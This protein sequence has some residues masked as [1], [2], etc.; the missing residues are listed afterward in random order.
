MNEKRLLLE[1]NALKFKIDPTEEDLERISEIE[2]E[3]IEL[4]DLTY[5]ALR[6]EE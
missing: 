1:L 4:Q 3:L 6:D 5:E 2:A